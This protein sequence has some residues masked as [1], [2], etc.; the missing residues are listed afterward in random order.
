MASCSIVSDTSLDSL[1]ILP[2]VDDDSDVIAFVCL[3]NKEGGK[4]FVCVL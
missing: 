3:L 1:L 4:R 2:V